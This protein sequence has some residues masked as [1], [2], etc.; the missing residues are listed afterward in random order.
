MMDSKHIT[1]R[2]SN[3]DFSLSDQKKKK[4]KH[5]SNKLDF[6]LIKHVAIQNYLWQCVIN[7]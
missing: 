1:E 2:H 7:A 3:L 5:C 4:K 6:I